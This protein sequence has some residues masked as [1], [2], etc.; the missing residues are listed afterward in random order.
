M[1]SPVR[2]V[3][4]VALGWR[5]TTVTAASSANV[6]ARRERARRPPRPAARPGRDVEPG[7][8]DLGLGVAEADVVLEHLRARRA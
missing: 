6:G 1:T 8:H 2:G 4:G 5:S 7:Q 3:A